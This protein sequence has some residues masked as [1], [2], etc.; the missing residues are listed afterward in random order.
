MKS[1]KHK[2]KSKKKSKKKSKEKEIEK[3]EPEESL[4]GVQLNRIK[5]FKH[6][7]LNEHL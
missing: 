1:K 6:F 4:F 2:F 3:K 7:E 5:Y